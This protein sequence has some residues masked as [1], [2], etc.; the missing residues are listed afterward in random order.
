M[1]R[2]THCYNHVLTDGAPNIRGGRSEEEEEE[3]D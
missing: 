1:L 3:E 2:L